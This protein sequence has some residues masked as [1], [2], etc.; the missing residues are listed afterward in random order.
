MKKISIITNG[1]GI[2][3][4]KS[5]YGQASD[6]VQN[7]LSD[8]DVDVKV[9]KA[10]EMEDFSSERDDAWIITGSAYSVYDDFPWINRLKEFIH[11]IVQENKYVL[12]I[13]FG[14]QII[15]ESCGGKVEKN[16]MG[17][18]LGSY[19]ITLSEEVHPIHFSQTLCSMLFPLISTSGLPGNL[20]EAYL[21]GITSK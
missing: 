10:Y 4:V 13:C 6:W 8:Y 2:A 18:E 11:K 20:D 21:A 17:W 14:H 5:L 1:P 19:P 12:G 9:V 15:A 7:V 16:K 3:E